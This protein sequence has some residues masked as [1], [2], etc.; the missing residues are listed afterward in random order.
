MQ[1]A[2]NR[3]QIR[4]AIDLQPE[5]R[6][7]SRPVPDR[8]REVQRWLFDP[9]ICAGRAPAARVCLKQTGIKIE[10]L[11]EVVDPDMHVQ[12]LHETS[13]FTRFAGLQ[14]A[15]GAHFSG[16]PPQQFCVRKPSNAFMVS[17]RAA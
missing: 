15:T 16:A 4:R 9:P 17:K 1:N 5:M 14:V 11:R 6:R 8:S 2:R 10:R 12:A 3:M 7:T 13:P